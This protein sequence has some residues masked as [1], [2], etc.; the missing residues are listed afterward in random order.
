VSAIM[1][2]AIREVG[3][4]VQEQH[5]DREWCKRHP[6]PGSMAEILRQ[7]QHQDREWCKRHQYPG[8]M[9]EI[10][11]QELDARTLSPPYRVACGVD[12]CRGSRGAAPLS[13]LS[14]M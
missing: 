6:Y 3:R 4:Q 8:S 12:D 2:S 10:L 13:I 11:R 1:K 9:A 7:E 5:Q 14:K